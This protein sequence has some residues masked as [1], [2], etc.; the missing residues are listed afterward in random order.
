[1]KIQWFL[2]TSLAVLALAGTSAAFAQTTTP[3]EGINGGDIVVTAQKRSQ[4]LIDVPVAVS[5]I[6]SDSL[7]TQNLNTLR[8]YFSLLPVLKY[9]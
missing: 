7:A 3:A 5:A 2:N 8:D 1:M 4:R 9:G 6:D